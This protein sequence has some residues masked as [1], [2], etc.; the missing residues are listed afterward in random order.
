MLASGV[1]TKSD[2]CNNEFGLGYIGQL[3]A[4]SFLLAFDVLVVILF[5]IHFVFLNFIID[6]C[7]LDLGKLFKMFRIRAFPKSF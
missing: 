7:I 6:S 2:T 5:G 4:I 3:L 1:V